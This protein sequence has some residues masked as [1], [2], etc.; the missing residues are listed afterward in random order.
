MTTVLSTMLCFSSIILSASKRGDMIGGIIGTIIIVIFAILGYVFMIGY[1][2]NKK[3]ENSDNSSVGC[4]I[5]VCVIG[6]IVTVAI[7]FS[8]CSWKR[9]MA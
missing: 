3:H 9:R 6:I 8:K 5:A 7:L 4:M 1:S 2:E